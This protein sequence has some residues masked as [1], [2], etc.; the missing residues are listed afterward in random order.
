MRIEGYEDLGGPLFAGEPLTARPGFWSNHLLGLCAR[1]PGGEPEWF[2]DDGADADAMSDVLWNPEGRPVFRVPLA[3][4]HGIAVIY[5]NIVGDYGIDYVATR[6]GGHHAQ[7][8]ATWEGDLVGDT[9]TWPELVRIAAD[10]PS[11][12]ADGLT[13]PAARLLLL[14][15]LLRDPA[16]PTEASTY[17]TTV[18]ITAGAPQHTAPATAGHLLDHASAAVWHD[19]TWPSPL[20][21]GTSPVRPTG[22]GL[23]TRLGVIPVVPTRDRA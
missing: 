4:G 2:G 17:L 23:L 19:P 21:G 15:P 6:P 3:N 5:R 18:L 10:T 11:A 1:G 9:V 12:P 14:L 7:Q 13:D 20:S 8:F 16:P 22:S